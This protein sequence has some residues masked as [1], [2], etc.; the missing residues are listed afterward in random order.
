M[1]ESSRHI[2]RSQILGKLHFPP[3]F[4]SELLE[5]K[6]VTID[7]QTEEKRQ[8]VRNDKMKKST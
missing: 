4:H 6:C 5:L 1:I 8:G 7:H 3:P 2:R